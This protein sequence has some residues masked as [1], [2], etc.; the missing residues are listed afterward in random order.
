MCEN[1]FLR[2]YKFHF[3]FILIAGFIL[4]S[5]AENQQSSLPATQCVIQPTVEIKG[6]Y[7]FFSDSKMRKIYNSFGIGVQ[8][9][10][11][12]PIW[13]CLQIYGSVGYIEKT[14]RS[15]NGQQKTRIWQIPLSLGLMPII[16]IS[17]NVQY[18]FSLGPRYFFVI[19]HNHSN[20]VDKKISNNG[21]GGYVNTGFRF[22]P[23]HHLLVD[24]FGEYSYK[25]MHF[26]SSKCNV[27]TRT[28]QIGGFYFG[29]GLGYAF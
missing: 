9:S 14:G 5:F 11:S 4:N 18:Y 17:Q 25:R 1:V 6:G 2:M 21:I 28:M 10:G 24:V 26:H 3:V 23:W 22:F 7:F 15:L 13:R 12:Y 19:Q 29:V 20:Y 8:V 16:Q 27:Y